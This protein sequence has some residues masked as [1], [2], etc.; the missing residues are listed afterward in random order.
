MTI[1]QATLDRLDAIYDAGGDVPE[2]LD[3]FA[4]YQ[5]ILPL[6]GSTD[7]PLRERKVLGV[8]FVWIKRRVL[9]DEQ[10]RALLKILL[11]EKHLFVGIGESG[12]DTVYM[13][14]FAV[15]LLTAFV[16]THQVQAYLPANELEDVRSALIRYLD[17]E[18]DLRG[19]ISPETW[20]GHAVAHAADVVRDL[21]RCEEF[22]AEALTELLEASTRAMLVD[23]SVFIHEED[24]RIATAILAILKRGLLSE[25]TLTRWS[26]SM[27]PEARWTG[28]LPGVHLRY[29][30]ARNLLRCLIHQGRV[31]ELDAGILEK[32]KEAHASLPER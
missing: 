15:F 11:D 7:G 19:Y 31:N 1:T 4:F 6:L 5:E 26:E 8:L 20:W 23:T 10:I 28:E 32:I 27:I 14:A 9:S 16:Q 17:E 29:V 25:E 3:P 22:G 18:K 24:A 21:A 13:R 12:T 2:D 30:N